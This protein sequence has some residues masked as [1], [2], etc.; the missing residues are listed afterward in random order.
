MGEAPGKTGDF[1]NLRRSGARPGA[2]LILGTA[3]GRARDA[4]AGAL[5]AA[6]VSPN[7]LSWVGFVMACGA[8]VCFGAGAGHALPWEGARAAVASWWPII[9]AVFL[10]ASGS[11]DMLDGALARRGRLQSD[12]GALL[13]S[14]LDRLSD[15]VIFLGCA[16]HFALA[17]NVTLVVLSI[18][19]IGSGFLVSYVKA[20]AENLVD[21]CS[22]GYWQRGERLVIFVVAAL[23]GHVPAG[24]WL[25]AVGPMFTVARRVRHGYVLLSGTGGRDPDGWGQRLAIWHSPRGSLGY[26]LCT[27]LLVGFVL[28]APWIHP[29]FTGSADPLRTIVE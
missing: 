18:L 28:V 14:T 25:L 21:R 10:A 11:V 16:I 12:F 27:A 29:V 6:G 17:G 1:V 8:A 20:R 9:G 4:V 24:L 7:V 2:G 3:V 5:V 26:D 22:V 23:V 13:D 15:L 19:A